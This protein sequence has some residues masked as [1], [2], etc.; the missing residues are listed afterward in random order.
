[1]ATTNP[2]NTMTIEINGTRVTINIEDPNATVEAN[3]VPAAPARVDPVTVPD[4]GP[5][6]QA[7]TNRNPLWRAFRQEDLGDAVRECLAEAIVEGGDT[8]TTFWADFNK[9]AGRLEGGNFDAVFDHQAGVAETLT[10]DHAG[11]E[12]YEDTNDAT[13]VSCASGIIT[14]QGI[15]GATV[16]PVLAAIA[17]DILRARQRGYVVVA[18]VG[19]RL[20]VARV[21]Q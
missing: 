1:M 3:P 12:W 9:F 5:N 2:L 14:M 21:K 17:T 6:G 15:R 11:D 13:L 20:F 10:A 16:P 19:Y 4:T 7:M 8:T 18:L